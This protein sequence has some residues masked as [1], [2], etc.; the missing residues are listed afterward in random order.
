M[1]REAHTSRLHKAAFEIAALELADI[2]HPDLRAN[3]SVDETTRRHCCAGS[4][5]R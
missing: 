1:R 2:L 3:A 5:F 4:Q